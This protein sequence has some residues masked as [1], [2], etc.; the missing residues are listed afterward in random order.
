[1]T[2]SHTASRTRTQTA[3]GTRVTSF[4][5]SFS[6]GIMCCVLL[7]SVLSFVSAMVRRGSRIYKLWTCFTIWRYQR[8]HS[9]SQADFFMIN[10]VTFRT[11]NPARTQADCPRLFLRK[12]I[13]YIQNVKPFIVLKATSSGTVTTASKFRTILVVGVIILMFNI[14]V[15]IAL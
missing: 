14:P 9:S 7:H 6:D 5:F 4:A 8:T 3:G 10:S 11:S 15:T 2:N 12:I 13:S 1:M